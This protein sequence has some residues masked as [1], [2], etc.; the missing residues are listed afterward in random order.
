M[1][2][3]TFLE[4]VLLSAGDIFCNW[5]GTNISDVLFCVGLDGIVS[6]GQDSFAPCLQFFNLEDDML[7]LSFSSLFFPFLY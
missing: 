2:N 4:V 5:P 6:S 3:N 1:E 7:D